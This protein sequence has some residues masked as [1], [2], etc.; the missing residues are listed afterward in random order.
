MDRAA[1]NGHLNVVKFLHEHRKEGC[2]KDA[3]NEAAA[4]NHLEILKYLCSTVGAKCS[5]VSVKAA[6]VNGHLDTVKWLVEEPS[7]RVSCTI[8]VMKAA[9]KAGQCDVVKWL[10]FHVGLPLYA[11]S[12]VPWIEALCG[13]LSFREL[14]I[15]CL[16]ADF[17]CWPFQWIG[18]W[19]ENEEPAA[20]GSIFLVFSADPTNR[21]NNRERLQRVRE[22][23]EILNMLAMVNNRAFIQIASR[24]MTVEEENDD[25]NGAP[26]LV[27]PM[28]KCRLVGGI[29][30]ESP[31]ATQS[32][33][34]WAELLGFP[35]DPWEYSAEFREM[36]GNLAAMSGKSG[37]WWNSYTVVEWRTGP[38]AM[39]IRGIQRNPWG[40]SEP[41]STPEMFARELGKRMDFFVPPAVHASIAC[42][43]APLLDAW[44][45]R[46]PAV[47]L[48]AL[49]NRLSTL[50]SDF[51]DLTVVQLTEALARADMASLTIRL[52]DRLTGRHLWG[53]AAMNASRL[54]T[55]LL[56]DRSIAQYP[57]GN[58]EPMVRRGSLPD[59]R[60][61]YL[62]ASDRILGGFYSALA[63]STIRNISSHMY[64]EFDD[65]DAED[66]NGDDSW[67]HRSNHD[68]W[69]WLAYALWSTTASPF[70]QHIDLTTFQLTADD[71]SEVEAVLKTG[72][73]EPVLAESGTSPDSSGYGFV[74]LR[75]GTEFQ[76]YGLDDGD[77][78]TFALSR[79]CRCRARYD[80]ATMSD[81]ADV[82]IP[83]LGICKVNLNDEARFVAD[84]PTEPEATCLRDVDY[85]KLFVAKI[86]SVE[87]LIRLFALVGG[88]LDTLWFGNT[89]TDLHIVDLSAL[90]AACPELQELTL[91]DVR[92]VVSDYSE[93]LRKW[94]LKTLLIDGVVSG[95][96]LCLSDPSFRMA[97]ELVKV[98]IDV[99]AHWN[100]SEESGGELSTHDGDFLAVTKEKFPRLSK[101]ALISVWSSESGSKAVSRMDVNMLKLIFTFAATPEKRSVQ[102]IRN[103][104]RFS[105]VHID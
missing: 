99:P 31:L 61:S 70:I 78:T 82:V 92:V 75:N 22:A 91:S 33:V 35:D 68:Q 52:D 51:S 87:V 93:A 83:G 66:V 39:P 74:E 21:E 57:G 16:H 54:F 85:F 15:P 64:V 97:R 89:G 105:I 76:P 46:E 1:A 18:E 28:W 27:C 23:I 45:D 41:T 80:S 38:N 40:D 47:P 79:D 90:A 10:Y 12:L 95:L 25:N 29:P 86:E 48:H 65:E 71:L 14:Q 96:G 60:V 69:K 2:S 94:P 3:T 24:F 67:T 17:K 81:H 11:G 13:S 30:V 8:K 84:A 20:I 73:P 98:T 32:S 5:S 102:I 101:A 88:R 103:S 77:D 37:D 72:F 43:I 62:W 42:S 56:C 36:M 49:E 59:I 6:A 19:D 100:F 44:K 9:M 55:T 58:E 4:G 63:A 50:K 34:S 26:R 7:T 53:Q 104:G